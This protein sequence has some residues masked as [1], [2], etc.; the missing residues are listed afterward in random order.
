[1]SDHMSAVWMEQELG[2]HVRAYFDQYQDPRLAVIVPG[3]LRVTPRDEL[4]RRAF[5]ERQAKRQAGPKVV[6][7]GRR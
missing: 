7:I 2:R 6:S 1:M 3:S 4:E 5:W